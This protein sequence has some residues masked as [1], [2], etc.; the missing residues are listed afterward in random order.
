MKNKDKYDVRLLVIRP[1]YMVSGC[2]KKITDNF[3]FDIYYQG[4]RVAKD[5][6]AKQ[7]TGKYFLEWLEADD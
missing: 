2:G 7:G 4:K 3:T 5:I 1:K 6:K